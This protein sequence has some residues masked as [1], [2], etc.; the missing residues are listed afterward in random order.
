[1]VRHALEVH[2][3]CTPQAHR[4]SYADPVEAVAAAANRC[5]TGAGVTAVVLH[6]V[7]EE[8]HP[9]LVAIPGSEGVLH[10]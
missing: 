6:R 8:K 2:Y 1:M 5:K 9:G 7:V 3:A 4:V 10:A